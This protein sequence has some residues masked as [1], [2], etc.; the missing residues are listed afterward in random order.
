MVIFIHIQSA[1]GCT[2]NTKHHTGTGGRIARLM[3]AVI[4]RLNHR[5][6]TGLQDN[7]FDFMEAG[8]S[9]PGLI[10]L[11][12]ISDHFDL[13]RDA[14]VNAPGIVVMDGCILPR[15]VDV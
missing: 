14:A 12:A 15:F 8:V 3:D 2:I 9:L 10:V 7:P 1:D 13:F 11:P 4:Q 6:V 5:C